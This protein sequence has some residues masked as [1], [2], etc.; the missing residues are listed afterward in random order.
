MRG[1][2]ALLGDRAADAGE[3]IRAIRVASATHATRALVSNNGEMEYPPAA[4]IPLCSPVSNT[5]SRFVERITARVRAVL[6]VAVT[7]ASAKSGRL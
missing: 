7:K 3:A 2:G 1:S 4:P 6:I 5:T